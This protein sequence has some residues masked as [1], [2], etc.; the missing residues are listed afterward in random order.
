M[1]LTAEQQQIVDAPDGP[2]TVTACAGS[3]KTRTAVHRLAELRRR[4]GMQ[5]GRAVLL[6]FTNVAVDT[7]RHEY[8]ALSREFS[9]DV[10]HDGVEID[11]LDAFLC[12]RVIRPHG[13]RTMGSTRMPY[14]VNGTEPF[15]SRFVIPG[16]DFP[17]PITNLNAIR[18]GDGFQFE[19]RYRGARVSIDHAAAR[20]QVSRLGQVGAY[21]HS[22]TPYWAIRTLED[23][24]GIRRALVRRYPRI[25]V[26][27]AQDFGPC[28]QAVLELLANAGCELSLIGDPNQGIYAFNGA[29]GSFLT[30][31]AARSGARTFDLTVNH[32]SVPA[33]LEVANRLS[34]RHD[35]SSLTANGGG[36][37][38]FFVSYQT[39][40]ERRLL[41]AF[42]VAVNALGLDI[43]QSAV[44][45]RGAELAGQLDGSN[46]DVGQGQVQALARAALLRDQHGRFDEAFALVASAV[47]NLLDDAPNDFLVQVR[48][49]ARTAG[50][51]DVR[52]VIW[53]FTRNSDE[54][55]PASHLVANAEWHRLL[56]ARAAMLLQVIAPLLSCV[57]PARLGSRLA[58][59]RLPA[60]PLLE[61]PDLGAQRPQRIRCDTVHKS[62]GESLDAILYLATRQHAEQMLNGVETELGRIG[63]VAVTRARR[64]LWVAVPRSAL[65]SLR[66]RLIAA[67]LVEHAGH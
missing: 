36:E 38:A 60:V 1:T 45:C 52:R 50:M 44:L 58:N 3:G 54:G 55:L 59:R 4:M 14:L 28:H 67:G 8:R 30:G 63:Y 33:I 34:G 20:R 37:G 51:R 19:C 5:R 13:H 7:F 56:V 61:R 24:P 49:T 42:S 22:L 23:Q 25:L 31:Y 15:L 10:R 6:S 47:A 21:T 39:A 29:D 40:D 11:T 17:Q 41:E 62:K 48:D 64:L 2:L 35:S 26:D 12:G 46:S 32:R 65:S 43:A 18:D 53:Q 66:G 27:E 57:P 9:R 16:G